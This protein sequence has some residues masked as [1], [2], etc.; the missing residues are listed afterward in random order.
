MSPD[1]AG[2]R[3]ISRYFCTEKYRKVIRKLHRYIHKGKQPKQGTESNGTPTDMRRTHHQPVPT[4]SDLH[5]EDGLE[6]ERH[7]KRCK[8]H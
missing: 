8:E 3:R 1:V 4:G 7:G 5:R 2:C 6:V